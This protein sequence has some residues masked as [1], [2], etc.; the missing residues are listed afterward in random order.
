MI[1]KILLADIKWKNWFALKPSDLSLLC[2]HV[3]SHQYFNYF[4]AKIKRE[5]DDSVEGKI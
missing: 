3:K 5:V 2:D 4:I 1:K